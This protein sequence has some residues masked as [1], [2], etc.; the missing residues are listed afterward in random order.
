M[1]G[2]EMQLD[3]I[4]QRLKDH[5]EAI[6]IGSAFSELLDLK[7]KK[8]AEAALLRKAATAKTLSEKT[9]PADKKKNKGPTKEQ[10]LAFKNMHDAVSK[11]SSLEALEFFCVVC[12]K[13]HEA[14]TE[15]QL[16]KKTCLR[17]S[18]RDAQLQI[19]NNSQPSFTEYSSIKIF[20]GGAPSLGKRR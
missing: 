14:E 8:K 19:G 12:E 16:I 20:S 10:R 4:T 5:F 3:P 13:K 18:G 6:R 9:K 7:R 1:T 2:P 15:Q 11:R 17:C